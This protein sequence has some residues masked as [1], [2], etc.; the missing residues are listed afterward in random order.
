[1]L[2]VDMWLKSFT[3]S[4]YLHWQSWFNLQIITNG[5]YPSIEHRATVNSEKER[6][7]L[8]TFYGPN[9]QA[10]LA[11]APSLV[12]QERPAQ[13]RKISVVDHFNGYFSQE[14]RGKSYLN[15]MKITQG[16]EW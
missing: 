4:E 14:L 6:I 2:E 11:P 10:I 8:A 3:I 16:V 13:F 5:I 12:T 7:S 9:M 1:M 15:Q